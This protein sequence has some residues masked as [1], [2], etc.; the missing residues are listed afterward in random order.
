MNDNTPRDERDTDPA[1]PLHHCHDCKALL[2]L[3]DLTLEHPL[4]WCQAWAAKVM[5]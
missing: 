4:P 5:P 3:D 2:E 1:P